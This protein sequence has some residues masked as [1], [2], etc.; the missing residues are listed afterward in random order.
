[1]AGS[2]EDIADTVT[3]TA[4][5]CW[6]CFFFEEPYCVYYHRH[7][8]YEKDECIKKPEWCRVSRIIIEFGR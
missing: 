6:R 8:D 1:M 5:E 7:F 2:V 3:Y 4:R